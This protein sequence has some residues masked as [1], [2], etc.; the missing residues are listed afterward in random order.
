MTIAVTTPTGNVGSRVVRLLVQAGLR[1]RVLVRDPARLDPGLRPLVDVA[2]GDLLDEAFVADALKGVEA[3]FWAS[4]ESFTSP[5]PLLTVKYG[6][7]NAC[8]ASNV[9]TTSSKVRSK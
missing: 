6:I 8:S 4:P 2:Q 5:D 3:L 7:P 9:G 1:P